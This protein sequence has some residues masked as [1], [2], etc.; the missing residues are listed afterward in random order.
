VAKSRGW[1]QIEA[2]AQAFRQMPKPPLPNGEDGIVYTFR[3]LAASHLA[4]TRSLKGDA[5]A[6]QLAEI[7]SSLPACGS[8]K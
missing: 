8:S 6:A 2:L 5:V 1:D 4:E 3:Q 7:Y